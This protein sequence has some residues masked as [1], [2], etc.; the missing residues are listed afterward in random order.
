[1]PT[2]P[3]KAQCW[4]CQQAHGTGHLQPPR[5][6]IPWAQPGLREKEAYKLLILLVDVAAN[7]PKCFLIPLF[8]PHG[9]FNSQP[10]I[11]QEKEKQKPN[12]PKC[13]YDVSSIC[14]DVLFCFFMERSNVIP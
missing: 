7:S 11:S 14:K 4:G 3:A 5:V 13:E 6:V 9:T 1:M 10:D 12:N 8:E 2:L